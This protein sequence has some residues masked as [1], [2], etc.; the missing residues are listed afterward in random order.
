M[1]MSARM[2]KSGTTSNPQNPNAI[3]LL[4]ASA[5]A[6]RCSNAVG[7]KGFAVMTTFAISRLSF[8]FHSLDDQIRG[9]IDSAGDD[10]EDNSEDKENAVMF[11]PMHGLAHFRRDGCR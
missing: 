11:V 3:H 10:K 7:A 6:L 1:K 9:D 4:R 2:S 8:A 5:R